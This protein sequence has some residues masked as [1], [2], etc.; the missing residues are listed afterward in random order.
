[1]KYSKQTFMDAMH[2]ATAK[3]AAQLFHG[4]SLFNLTSNK[5]NN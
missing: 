2:F 3:N 4:V 5:E 1:M